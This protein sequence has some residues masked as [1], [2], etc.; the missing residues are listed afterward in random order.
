VV[1]T[2][3]V[4]DVVTGGA[5]VVVVTGGAVVVVSGGRVVVVVDEVDVVVDEVVVVRATA[6]LSSVALPIATPMPAPAS[7]RTNAMPQTPAGLMPTPSP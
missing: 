5:V 4:V 7:N 6:V 2:G 3:T 1:V